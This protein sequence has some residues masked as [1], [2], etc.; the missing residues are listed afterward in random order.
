MVFEQFDE[1][2]QMG[3]HG[4]P[5]LRAVFLMARHCTM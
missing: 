5:G 2:P 3:V 1:R 4:W